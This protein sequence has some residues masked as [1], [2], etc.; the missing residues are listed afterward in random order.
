LVELVFH[1]DFVQLELVE[2]DRILFVMAD[3]LECL[4]GIDV[5]G[6][7]VSV[8]CE[9]FLLSAFSNDIHHF[10]VFQK[11]FLNGVKLAHEQGL[12]QPHRAH[13]NQPEVPRLGW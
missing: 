8:Q 1:L 2:E 5:F 9:A 12:V 3:H 4:V 11:V 6:E 7:E 10:L 13:F